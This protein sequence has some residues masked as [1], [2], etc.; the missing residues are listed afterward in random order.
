LVHAAD[1][2]FQIPADKKLSFIS[3]QES[4]LLQD[5]VHVKTV[6]KF[7]GKCI[8]FTK[9]YIRAMA[10]AISKAE[11][12]TQPIY[13]QGDVREE[14]MVWNFIDSFPDK[15]PW[16]DQKHVALQF[17]TDAS[18]FAWGASVAGET[19]HDRWAESDTRPIHLKETDALI[20]TIQAMQD[21]LRNKRVDALV[22]NQALIAAWQRLGSRDAAFNSLLK[23]LI[24][25]VAS[26]NCDLALKYIRSA[27]NPADAPSR[28]LSLQDA[29]LSSGTWDILQSR[30]GPYTFDLMSLDSNVMCDLK[31]NPLPHYT[32]YP[33][34]NSAGVNVLSQSLSADQNYY[35]FP[36]FCMLGPVVAFLLQECPS[37]I[38]VTLVV[39]RMNPL[40][41][42]WPA[43]VHRSKDSIV[44]GK[45]GNVHVIEAPGAQGFMPHKLHHILVAYRIA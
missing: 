24:Q 7:L 41:A 29:H 2:Y 35:C 38:K 18:G 1:R 45:L 4:I 21:T 23:Q 42:W 14:I 8:S 15:S 17:A 39:P 22:D 37:D 10:A 12:S 6:Q 9:L 31:G 27:E 20:H 26:I 30:W 40:P 16:R 44:L 11:R 3:L 36:P 34:P 33:L 13:I 5:R 32:P 43:L 19:L 25:L 28:R